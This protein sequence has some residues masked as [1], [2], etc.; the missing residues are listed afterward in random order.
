M[1]RSLVL[2]LWA[3]AVLAVLPP[4]TAQ[5]QQLS[6]TLKKIKDTGTL[7]IGYRE[8]SRPFSFVGTDGKP[9][10]YSIELCQRIAAAVQQELGLQDLNIKYVPV[11]VENRI[12]A[13]VNKTVDIECGSTT[14]TLSRQEQVDFTNPTFLD[15]GGLLVMA[16][17]G[18]NGIGDLGGKRVAVIPGTTTEPVLKAALQRG[19]LVASTVPVKDHNEGLA[20]LETG[21]AD[22]YASDR[23]ILIGL[24]F[25]AKDPKKLALA[26]QMFSYEP[27]GLMLPR[28]DA[29]F[30]L[31]ANRALARIYRSDQIGLIFGKWFGSLGRPTG[32]LLAVYLINGFPE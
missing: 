17:S 12:Q 16:G 15:G 21:M 14:I 11:T 31:T 3:A 6:G 5:T 7:V 2:F 24:G 13:V 19:F 20:V 23:T 28:G 27:Y 22:A 10:G 25:G 1:K 26:E 9:T 32:L 8:N 30:R 18:I 29:A 4:S